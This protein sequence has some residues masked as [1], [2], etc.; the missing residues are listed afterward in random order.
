[1][2]IQEATK[3]REEL[4]A[5]Q[6][7]YN[8]MV[9]ILKSDT[10]ENCYKLQML[11]DEYTARSERITQQI[12]ALAER[13]IADQKRKES[14]EAVQAFDTLIDTLTHVRNDIKAGKNTIHNP[15]DLL[16]LLA[17]GTKF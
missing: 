14:E 2:T 3:L 10:F 9:K 11:I 7:Q 12:Q 4:L 5:K 16:S 17:S 8:Q 6:R 15:I 1:M 13:V